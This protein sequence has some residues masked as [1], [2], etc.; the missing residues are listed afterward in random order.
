M[1]KLESVFKHLKKKPPEQHISLMPIGFETIF[2]VVLIKI[3]T[4]IEYNKIK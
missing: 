2:I 1:V 3:E 4:K